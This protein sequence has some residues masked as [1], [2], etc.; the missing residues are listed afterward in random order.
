MDWL[1]SPDATVQSS[2]RLFRRPFPSDSLY[3]L[4]VEA[5]GFVFVQSTLG[6][7]LMQLGPR[8]ALK[9]HH[10]LCPGD[11]PE[12]RGAPRSNPTSLCSRVVSTSAGVG[13]T[14]AAY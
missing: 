11:A 9:E 10:A 6:D 4:W 14:L 2:G 1:L 13:H 12:Y 8:S 5:H 3:L 7:P